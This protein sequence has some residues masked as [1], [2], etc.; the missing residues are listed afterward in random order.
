LENAAA[1]LPTGMSRP[2][3]SFPAK[4]SEVLEDI[5]EMPRA[6][7]IEVHPSIA[8]AILRGHGDIY[9]PTNVSVGQ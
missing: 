4:N 8:L 2:T 6:G 1:S 3:V 7:P 5:Q 9:L